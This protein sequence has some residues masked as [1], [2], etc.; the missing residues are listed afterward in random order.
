MMRK[1]H[2]ILVINDQPIG[3]KWNYDHSNR[4]KYKG[5]VAIPAPRSFSKDVLSVV[6]DIQMAEVKTFGEIDTENFPWPTTRKESI[7]LL[8]YFCTNLLAYFGEYQDALYSEHAY[9]FHSRLSFAMNSKMISPKEV[10]DTVITYFNNNQDTIEISQVEGFIRQIIGWREYVRGIYWKEMPN[11]A[12]MNA[13]DNQNKLPA[14]FWTGETKMK[15]MQHAISQSLTEAYAHHIQRLMI[16]GNFSLLTQIHPDE[17]D[18][19][20]LG[21]YIDAIEWVEMPNTRGMSQYADGGIIATKPYVSSGSYINK[22]SNYCGDCKYNVKEKVGEKACP[23]NSLYWNFL[24]DKREHF[25]NNQRMNMM[26]ALLNKMKPEELISIKEKA[27]HIIENLD[28]Y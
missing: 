18:A 4:N 13:L 25:K 14:F 1:R 21:V 5:E 7:E 17:V 10:V 23:F 27:Q 2:H 24:D 3:G 6:N 12:K 9:L 19:W 16:I 28:S 15:C 26:M 22:M 20:Y 11:Y 8:D